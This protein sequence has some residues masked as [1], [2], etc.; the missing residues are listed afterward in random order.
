MLISLP[1]AT[2]RYHT[3]CHQQVRRANRTLCLQQAPPQKADYYTT[4]AALP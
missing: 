4:D 1:I 3:L 2:T